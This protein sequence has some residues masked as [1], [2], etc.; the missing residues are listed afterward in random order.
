MAFRDDPQRARVCLALLGKTDLRELWTENGPTE[1][2]RTLLTQGAKD[3][4]AE[5]R[6]LFLLAWEFWRA[7]TDLTF[8]DL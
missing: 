1:L 2:A 6:T 5:K 7:K 3:F 8:H 4:S